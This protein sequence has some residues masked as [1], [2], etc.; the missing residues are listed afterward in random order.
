MIMFLVEL[1][2]NARAKLVHC[3]IT[4]F[5]RDFF[6]AVLRTSKFEWHRRLYVN[7]ARA[8]LLLLLLAVTFI[9][10]A[11]LLAE[12]AARLLFGSFRHIG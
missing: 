4:R 2:L 5:H 6:Q 7:A 11:R 3:F 1:E 10:L 8:A 9:D 12:R